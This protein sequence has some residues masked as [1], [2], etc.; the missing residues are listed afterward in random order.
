MLTSFKTQQLQSKL[1]LR[2]ACMQAGGYGSQQ[3]KNKNKQKIQ[4]QITHLERIASDEFKASSIRQTYEMIYEKL[5]FLQKQ[6]SIQLGYSKGRPT[7][8]NSL[9]E[10]SPT[11]L[12]NLNHDRVSLSKIYCI[13]YLPSRRHICEKGG[14]YNV[15]PSLKNDFLN[16]QFHFNRWQTVPSPGVFH[17]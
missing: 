11:S 10:V 4:S 15:Y 2:L 16:F 3:N 7:L 12:N 1:R 5:E 8:T 14:C 9:L 13:Y 17:T 6:A